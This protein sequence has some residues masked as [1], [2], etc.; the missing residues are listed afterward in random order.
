MNSNSNNKTTSRPA[1]VNV[2]EAVINGRL[3]PNKENT[4]K[5]LKQ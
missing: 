1:F 5:N 4:V 3:Y 2:T